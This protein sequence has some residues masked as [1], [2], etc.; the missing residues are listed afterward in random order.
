DPQW[1]T[2]ADVIA[3]KIL[4][5]KCPEILEAIEF[6]PKEPQLGLRSVSIAGNSKYR[7]DPYRDD[8]FRRLIDLR[9]ATKA[10]I[11]SA[12]E[13]ERERLEAEQLALK[14]VAN[15]TSYG[16]SAEINVSDLDK[17]EP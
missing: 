8:F 7:I 2:L 15:A 16:I 5:G 3:S 17:C 11:K 1:V 12:T 6:S 9:A 10:K 13:A 4:T 14:I